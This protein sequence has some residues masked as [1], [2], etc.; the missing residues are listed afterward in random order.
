V[1]D[2]RTEHLEHLFAKINNCPTIEAERANYDAIFA[3]MDSEGNMDGIKALRGTWA[4]QIFLFQEMM[5]SRVFAESAK[6]AMSQLSEALA[7]A[8]YHSQK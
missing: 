6:H 1:I 5:G 4:Y 7:K 2:E 8:I 3:M